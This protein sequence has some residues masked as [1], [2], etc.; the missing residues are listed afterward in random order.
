MASVF[1][2]CQT[3]I[4]EGFFFFTPPNILTERI[5]GI[6]KLEYKS[7]RRRTTQVECNLFTISIH[8]FCSWA[9]RRRT[10]SEI[11]PFPCNNECIC[12]FTRIYLLVRKFHWEKRGG[13]NPII[14]FISGKQIQMEEN[15]TCLIM[16]FSYVCI[17]NFLFQTQWLYDRSCIFNKKPWK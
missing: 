2:H 17:W 10:S 4:Q 11:W 15:H 13:G 16:L 3:L 1:S 7:W 9:F 8:F 12:S 14:H 5:V 6:F